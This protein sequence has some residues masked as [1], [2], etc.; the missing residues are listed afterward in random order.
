[1]RSGG[2]DGAVLV[3]RHGLAINSASLAFIVAAVLAMMMKETRG[4]EITTLDRQASKR[5]RLRLCCRP[6]TF[7]LRKLRDLNII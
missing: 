1:M 2:K 7:L 6:A 3:P 4:I 5:W